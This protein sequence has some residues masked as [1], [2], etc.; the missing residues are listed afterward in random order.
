D[1]GR[2]RGDARGGVRPDRQHDAAALSHHAGRVRRCGPLLRLAVEPGGD[3]TESGGR[4][5]AGAGLSRPDSKASRTDIMSGVILIT[6]ATSGIGRAAARRF[7]GAGWKV[8]ATGRRQERLDELVA[9]LG[10]DRVHAAPLDMR[11]EA[12]NDATLYAQPG[13]F[14]DMD[15]LIDSV[16]RALGTARAQEAEVAEWRQMIDT[17]ITGL[18]TLTHRVLARL[19]A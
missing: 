8:I 3:G 5:R 7:A 10:A 12:A 19:I 4:R 13:G 2:Q 6:G 17:N 14:R 15:V 11:D 16:G 18:V 1:H 9:E